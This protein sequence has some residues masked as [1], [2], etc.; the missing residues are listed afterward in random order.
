MEHSTA[1]STIRR[2]FSAQNFR[3]SLE[4]ALKKL[5]LLLD[6]MEDPKSRI[7]C[8]RHAA[9][10]RYCFSASVQSDLHFSTLFYRVDMDPIMSY[11]AGKVWMSAFQ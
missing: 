11:I 8:R 9:V 7:R 2:K 6:K 1:G 3:V 10:P 4:E 5:E